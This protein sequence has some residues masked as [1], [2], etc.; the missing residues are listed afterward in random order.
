MGPSAFP[1]D[2]DHHH[3]V[4]MIISSPYDHH[5]LNMIISSPHKCGD[6]MI[7]H[8]AFGGCCTIVMG[9]RNIDCFFFIEKINEPNSIAMHH[10]L[11]MCR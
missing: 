1:F 11:L 6:N 10:A 2:N 9:L 3:H 4:I 8:M 7:I 5:N